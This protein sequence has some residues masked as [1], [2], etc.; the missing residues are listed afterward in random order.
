MQGIYTLM[1][2]IWSCPLESHHSFQ[3]H[4]TTS[5]DGTRLP[6]T[7]LGLNPSVMNLFTTMLR[8]Q[9]Y[10]I[11]Q[12]VEEVAGIQSMPPDQFRAYVTRQC[13]AMASFHHQHNR[14]YRGL[15]GNALPERW[16]DL[17]VMTKKDLQ[18]PLSNTLSTGYQDGNT[19]RNSTSGS[20]GTPFSFSKDKHSHAIMWALYFERYA[21][22]GIDYGASL[23]ARFYGIPLQGAKK[24]K[25]LA[26][27]FFAAR[28]RF[29][30]FNLS[31]EKLDSFIRRFQQQP[32]AYINGYTSSLVY[33][34]QYCLKKGIVLCSVCPTLKVTIPTSEMC[35][36]EDRLLMEKAFGVPVVN[37]Y[38]CAEA[39][40]L[41]IEDEQGDWILNNENVYFE[42]IDD[43][44]QPLPDGQS[45]KLVI[46]LLHNKAMP[47]IRYELGDMATLSVRRKGNHQLLHGLAGRT[48]EFAILPDGRKVPGL[49][50]YYI[51][52]AL[53]QHEI[54]EF[55]VKQQAHDRFLFEYV[56][57][58]SLSE[59]AKRHVYK[60][61]DVYLAPNLKAE[62]QQKDVI[63]RTSIGKLRQFYNCIPTD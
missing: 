44:H 39:G 60:A 29:P 58:K 49:T 31:D 2:Y 56:S 28:V 42:V 11:G 34:A 47:F 62:F 24:Y 45:G 41:A 16:E 22:H 14:M 53:I 20:S 25:E 19:Y 37:E 46:T 9:G 59:E 6:G 8:F 12:A 54:K 3:Y 7:T 15:V 27:D 4:C 21:R 57:E 48:N 18:Q 40:I 13:W 51:T 10:P 23:Q 52:K 50:F 32:V 35:S 1:G 43:Q 5:F 55:I 38:G 61:M 36:P 26:K 30:I 33:F 17:P 63:E